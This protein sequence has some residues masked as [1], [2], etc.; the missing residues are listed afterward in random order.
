MLFRSYINKIDREELGLEA[1]WD[2]LINSSLIG[3]LGES[4]LQDEVQE[5]SVVSLIRLESVKGGLIKLQHGLTREDS[6]IGR[7]SCRERV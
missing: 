6:E 1:P 5:M 3:I 7:A 4:A 2:V